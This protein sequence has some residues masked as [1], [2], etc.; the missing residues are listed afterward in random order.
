MITI[1]QHICNEQFG[2]NEMLVFTFDNGTWTSSVPVTQD[3]IEFLESVRT[4]YE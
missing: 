1:A 4:Q 2:I 3:M